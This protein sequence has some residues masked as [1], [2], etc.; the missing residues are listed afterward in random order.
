MK[1]FD[2]DSPLMSGLNK[3][4]DLMWLNV[5]T[6]LCCIPIVTAGAAFTAMH[7]ICLKIAR[8]EESY[9]TKNFFKSFKTNFKQAT[10]IWLIQLVIALFIFGDLWILYRSGIEFHMIFH[11][12]VILVAAITTL[13]SAFVF[14][15]LAKFDNTLGKIIKNSLVISMV[16]LPKSVLFV[17]MNIGAIALAIFV[18]AL[19]P[20]YFFFGLAM[21][22]F[23]FAKLYSKFFEKLENQIREANG[24]EDLGNDDEH[25]FSDETQI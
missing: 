8:D 11:V 25:I 14:P 19:I 5:L 9:I 16:Q 18:P 24:E 2:M 4:A 7:Y 6:F 3:F 1:M 20:L 22:A 10:I 21:P 12:A 17:V 15:V 13:I 23:V